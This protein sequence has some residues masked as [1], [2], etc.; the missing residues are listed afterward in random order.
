M[1][2]IRL[3]YKSNAL[4]LFTNVAVVLPCGSRV[5]Q[6]YD[7]RDIRY[8][9]LW[10]LHGGGGDEMEFIYNT[11]V[12]QYAE[13]SGIAVVSIAGANSCYMN[14]AYGQNF[15][16]LLTRELPSLLY[17]RFPISPKREDNYIAGFSM[18]AAGAAWAAVRC[19]ERYALCVPISGMADG[20]EDIELRRRT[21]PGPSKAHG[22]QVLDM[23]YG[24]DIIGTEHDFD[25]LLEESAKLD[26][27]FPVFRLIRGTY[28]TRVHARMQKYARRLKELGADVRPFTF[29]EGYSHDFLMC[30]DAIKLILREWIP[31]LR[32]SL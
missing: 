15:S 5:R 21:Q 24:T 9:V 3:N 8:P 31:E 14:T 25:H 7:T 10:L 22:G 2:F 6:E 11:C 18:G 19:P 17:A 16:D 23:I 28:D 30:E 12:E 1:S 20:P 27:G 32:A 26:C 29:F 13:E 4:N